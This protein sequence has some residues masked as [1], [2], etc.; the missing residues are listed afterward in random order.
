MQKRVIIKAVRLM[1]S[2]LDHTE[3]VVVFNEIYTLYISMQREQNMK[4]IYK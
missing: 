1:F 2:R 3:R 4:K